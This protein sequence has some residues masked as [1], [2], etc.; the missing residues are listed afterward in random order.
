VCFGIR[1]KRGLDAFV[2]A[3]DMRE[4]THAESGES[5][6]LLNVSKR[7]GYRVFAWTSD[8][9]ALEAEDELPHEAFTAPCLVGESAAAFSHW[10]VRADGRWEFRFV[11]SSD[12]RRNGMPVLSKTTGAWIGMYV[13]STWFD[14]PGRCVP[15]DALLGCSRVSPPEREADVALEREWDASREGPC[16]LPFRGF[17]IGDYVFA[18]TRE[19][20]CR[21]VANNRPRKVVLENECRYLSAGFE[22]AKRRYLRNESLAWMDGRPVVGQKRGSYGFHEDDDDEEEEEEEEESK[23]P[24][25]WPCEDWW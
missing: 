5:L 7:H 13:A 23:A 25:T 8:S 14:G 21:W 1:A 11:Q 20:K 16:A 15:V 24:T 2:V 4:A 19:G 6:R 10:F 17:E 3:P 12:P 22:D 18:E 9:D